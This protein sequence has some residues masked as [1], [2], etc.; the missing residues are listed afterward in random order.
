ML[1]YASLGDNKLK[2]L[3]LPNR[4]Y[5]LVLNVCQHFSLNDHFVERLAEVLY[6]IIRVL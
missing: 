3:T 2:G 1:K 6:H 4:Y 5:Y